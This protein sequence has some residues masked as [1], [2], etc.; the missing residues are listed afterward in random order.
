MPADFGLL[1]EK[2]YA[3]VARHHVWSPIVLAY[4]AARYVRRWIEWRRRTPQQR[5]SEIYERQVWKHG[6]APGS[7][8]GSSLAYTQSFRRGLEALLTE[9]GIKTLFDAPCGDM[10]WMRTV[11]LPAGTLYRGGDIVPPLIN[12]H[13]RAFDPAIY[14]FHV[15]DITRDSFP[16]ADLWLCRDCLF[17]LSYDDIF[18]ALGQ[19]VSSSIPLALITSHT[20]VQRNWDIDT[21]EWRCLDLTKAPFHLPAPAFAIEDWVE[22]HP[23]RVVGLWTRAEIAAALARRGGKSVEQHAAACG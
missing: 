12:E 11:T 13:R 4:K 9:R 1:V 14:Q 15:F 7:G 8:D 21:G 6:G 22:G 10:H 17:H 20:E 23:K 3:V 5:F 2:S 19:F 16:P 18:A